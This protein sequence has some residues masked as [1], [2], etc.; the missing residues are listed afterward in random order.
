[1]LLLLLLSLMP[2]AVRAATGDAQLLR[3]YNSA[4]VEVLTYNMSEVTNAFKASG[5]TYSQLRDCDVSLV[6]YPNTSVAEGSLR[7]V[8]R[9]RLFRCGEVANAPFWPIA[10]SLFRLVTAQ[11]SV[12]YGVHIEA[13]MLQYANDTALWEALDQQEIDCTCGT[14]GAGG[15]SMNQRRSVAWQRSCSTFSYYFKWASN[16]T[17]GISNFET[18]QQT[19]ESRFLIGTSTALGVY[20]LFQMQVVYQ[21]FNAAVYQ[22]QN[23]TEALSN[24]HARDELLAV[25]FDTANATSLVKYN[26]SIMTVQCSFFRKETADDHKYE[27]GSNL[28]YYKTGN[29]A[30]AQLYEAA[31][32]AT[33]INGQR[34]EVFKKWNISYVNT[35]DCVANQGTLQ[36]PN[37]TEGTLKR[38]LEKREL[39]LAD[40]PAANDLLDTSTPNPTGLLHVLNWI[41]AEWITKQYSLDEPLK[42]TYKF[43]NSSNEVFDAVKR[44][45]ADATSNFYYVGGQ[46]R[47]APRSIEFRPACYSFAYEMFILVK[48]SDHLA[49]VDD[50][51]AK[52]RANSHLYMGCVSDSNYWVLQS[53]L[54]ANSLNTFVT[55]IYDNDAVLRNL[56]S[57]DYDPNMTAVMPEWI[58]TPPSGWVMLT[59]SQV[60]PLVTFFRRDMLDS[61]SDDELDTAFGEQC[62]GGLGCS[63]CRCMDGFRPTDPISDDCAGGEHV[64]SGR[65]AL[66]TVCVAFF[67]AVVA[68]MVVLAMVLLFLRWRKVE[69]IVK[70]ILL[71]PGDEDTDEEPFVDSLSTAVDAGSF[72]L[73]VSMA[74]LTFGL[75]SHQADVDMQLTEEFTLRNKCKQ[76][77]SFKF[78]VRASHKYRLKFLP[79]SGVLHSHE[80]IQV[81]AVLIVTCTAKINTAVILAAKPGSEHENFFDKSASFSAA[82]HVFF[83]LCLESKL[84]MKLDPDEFELVT[85]QIGEGSFGHVFKADWRGQEC[86]VKLLKFQEFYEQDLREAF[87]REVH[88]METMRAPQIVNFLGAVHVPK[89]LALVTEYMPLGSLISTMQKNTFSVAL[90]LKCLLDCAK[91]MNFLHQSDVVHRDLKGDNLLMCSLDYTLPVTCKLSDFGTTRD[92]QPSE[93]GANF[94]QAIGTPTH[95]APEVLEHSS[96]SKSS[97]VYSFAVLAYQVLTEKEPYADFE[98]MW[99]VSKFVVEQKRLEIPADAPAPFSHIITT[100]WAQDPADRPSFTEVS[101]FLGGTL[102]MLTAPPS[103]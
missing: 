21:L 33:E 84:S 22:F 25:L 91:G 36:V 99:A 62:N 59:I 95:M 75:G 35:A 24:L 76:Q 5:F 20:T 82:H 94:T 88:L 61:C 52:L 73:E 77:H 68:F 81:T 17:A 48:E 29:E 53:L 56:S 15:Y 66:I 100:C 83:P 4:L 43:Y 101:A 19:V 71:T 3:V 51:F 32:M 90:K 10:K 47:G 7:D 42:I 9:K 67:V 55:M 70:E 49:T 65:V 78:F 97:D 8:L 46:Y 45:E 96:Y 74:K 39:V 11:I 50:L 34:D 89:R 69:P 28:T 27:Q 80:E 14:I 63:H 58:R 92:I 13:A 23:T 40:T 1:M 86:A 103:Q 26:S 38:V 60:Q 6:Q 85:P 64:N 31:F 72:N 93:Q 12:H 102:S 37:T 30:L 98:S 16:E 57:V 41:I 54:S 87:L 79:S 44:G 2:A 18:L